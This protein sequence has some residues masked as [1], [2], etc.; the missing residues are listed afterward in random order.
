MGLLRLFESCGLI[1]FFLMENDF[2]WDWTC[3]FFWFWG[4]LKRGFGRCWRLNRFYG[5]I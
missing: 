5:Y 4:F 1:G 2:C 3:G